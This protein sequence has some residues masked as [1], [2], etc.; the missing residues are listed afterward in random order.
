MEGNPR[1]HRRSFINCVEGRKT[2]TNSPVELGS[3][4][5]LVV[6]GADSL[7]IE[8]VV[9]VEVTIAAAAR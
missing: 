7:A 6:L 4:L 1:V 5:P 9:E 2:F 3:V 8:A